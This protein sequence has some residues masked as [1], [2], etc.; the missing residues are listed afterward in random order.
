MHPKLGPICINGTPKC[1][2]G[3]YLT[4]FS[5][6]RLKNYFGLE[7]LLVE[8]GVQDGGP[9]PILLNIPGLYAIVLSTASQKYC[10]DA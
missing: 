6:Y 1:M 4:T 9:Q 10:P 3:A 2:T 7:S 5:P 8:L